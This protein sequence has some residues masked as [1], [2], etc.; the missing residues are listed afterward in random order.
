MKKL[1]FLFVFASYAALLSAQT[2][3]NVMDSLIYYDGYAAIVTSPP[4]PA[5]VLKLRNDLFAR[6]LTGAELQSIGSTLQM[7]VVIHALCDNYDRIGNVNMALTPIGAT[8]Y[9]PD[10][11]ARI[12]LG[13][14]IT[15]FFN[16]NVHP[17]SVPYTFNIDNVAMLLRDTTITHHFDI[18]MELQ[19]FGVP[20]AANTQITGCSARNDVFLGR[21]QLVTNAPA[22]ATNDVLIPLFINHDF[23][24]YQAAATD[25][26]GK[27]TKTITYTVAD[28]LATAS[29]YLITSNHG[30]NSG[31]EEYNRRVHYAFYDD[32]L[33]L[34]Y[35]PGRTSCEPFRRYNTQGNGIYGSSPKSDASWQ[36]F[37]NWCPGDVIDIRMIDLGPVSAGSHKFM[38]TVPTAI[39]TGGQGN[40]PLSLYMQGKKASINTGIN[41]YS[42]EN[43]S[44]AIYPNP[45]RGQFTIETDA[46]NAEITVTDMLGKQIIKTT[47]TQKLTNLL[48]NENGVYIVYVSTQLG[49][50]ARKLVV[51]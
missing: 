20:Y 34:T 5:G 50:V 40:F 1:F 15:P 45:T 33:K 18:W 2:T 44:V 19:L 9:N 22:A 31:G 16:K 11:V 24:N 23:N 41:E 14:F 36:S 49:T 37:S 6:K 48:L 30:S 46:D 4:P 3:I 39:F 38:I 26:I 10:S 13:R 8:T 7:N 21:L 35:T 43:N 51:N 27:T 17:D 12:E 29:F 47:S 28:S 25:T 42:A 32:S